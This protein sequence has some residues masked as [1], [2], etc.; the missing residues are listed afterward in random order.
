M[1]RLEHGPEGIDVLANR[2]QG[3]HWKDVERVYLVCSDRNDNRPLWQGG[4]ARHCMDH[5]GISTRRLLG[6]VDWLRRLCGRALLVRGDALS[7][8]RC[9]GTRL[10]GTSTFK[11]R[12]CLIRALTGRPGS[13][14]QGLFLL[15][16]AEHGS[17]ANLVH[18]FL[19]LELV[20]IVGG[21]PTIVFTS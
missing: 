19:C 4:L 3:R 9:T 16:E 1:A 18:L 20:G 8:G 15:Q 17:F 21:N 5:L 12:P 14:V 11:T 2:Y 7:F 10:G 13:V 6:V